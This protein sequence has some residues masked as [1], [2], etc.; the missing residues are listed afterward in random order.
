[1]DKTTPE[2]VKIKEQES[3]D[4]ENFNSLDD[5]DKFKD[6]TLKNDN[7]QKKT[8]K[9]V[10]SKVDEFKNNYQEFYDLA[11]IG[12]F[13][14][15]KDRLI[16]DIN[17]EGESMLKASQ[18]YLMQKPFAHFLTESSRNKFDQHIKNVINA[19]GEQHCNLEL[20]CADKTREDVHVVTS[21]TRGYFRTVVTNMYQNNCDEKTSEMMMGDESYPEEYLLNWRNFSYNPPK[22]SS[23][24]TKMF[25]EDE[26]KELKEYNDNLEEMVKTRTRELERSNEDLKNFAY[27]ASHDLREPLR[28][29]T[30]F[31]QLIER[32]YSDKLDQEGLEFIK[33]AVDG[34]KRLDEMILDLLEYS[35][36]TRQGLEFNRVE[37]EHVLKQV[38]INLVVMIE[39]SCSVVTHDP[40]ISVN[41]DE[42]LLIQLFQNIISNAIK[43]RGV[44]TPHIHI[45]STKEKDHVLFSIKDN[46]IGMDPEHMKRIFKIFQRLN[47]RDEY[48]GTGIGLAISKKIVHQHGGVIWAKSEPGKGTTFYFTI[49]NRILKLKK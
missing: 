32:R 36:I 15:N 31:L 3:F 33:F 37:C 18:N 1:M 24:P 5:G 27:V 48:D 30:N 2:R 4:T 19:E 25:L 9:G 11:P 21:Y 34:A 26:S 42:K 8:V 16:T 23:P 49:P 46:G 40:L 35:K 14:L 12:Y 6:E 10:V 20:L 41:G 13:I 43:Y 17:R 47:K 28:M 22:H 29:I 7:N 45:S 44:E 38:L 39:E